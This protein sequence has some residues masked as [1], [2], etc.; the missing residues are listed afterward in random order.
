MAKG[1]MFEGLPSSISMADWHGCTDCVKSKST[2]RKRKRNNPFAPHPRLPSSPGDTW[3]S[4]QKGQISPISIHKNRYAILFVDDATG[5]TEVAF[6][7]SLADTEKAYDQ[8]SAH[9]KTQFGKNIKQFICDRH[10]TYV[11]MMPKLKAEG[12]TIQV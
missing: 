6:V 8:L 10:S 9:V 3:H 12:T 7:H 5:Y 11:T 4:D 2:K 1:D